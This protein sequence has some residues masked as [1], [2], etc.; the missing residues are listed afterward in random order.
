MNI[1]NLETFVDTNETL[2]KVFGYRGWIS[3]ESLAFKIE[4]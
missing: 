1:S 4:S 2:E 3:K